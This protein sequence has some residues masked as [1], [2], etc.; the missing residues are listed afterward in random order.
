MCHL[1][2]IHAETCRTNEIALLHSADLQCI[3]LLHCWV[4]VELLVLQRLAAQGHWDLL[5]QL[6]E[7]LLQQLL[8]FVGH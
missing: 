8:L 7:L 4:L 1:G 6:P 5:L 2:K 3:Y